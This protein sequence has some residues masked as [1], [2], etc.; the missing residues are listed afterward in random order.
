MEDEVKVTITKKVYDELIKDSK[1]LQ[2]LYA[3]GVDNWEWYEESLEAEH[4]DDE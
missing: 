4:L 2:L 1:I 3:G